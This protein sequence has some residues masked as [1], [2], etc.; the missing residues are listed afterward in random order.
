[1]YRSPGQSCSTTE[2]GV[3]I[4]TTRHKCSWIELLSKHPFEM[5]TDIGNYTGTLIYANLYGHEDLDKRHK[6]GRNV[7]KHEII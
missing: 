3:K 1:M 6:R 4:P 5:K 2:V 7:S